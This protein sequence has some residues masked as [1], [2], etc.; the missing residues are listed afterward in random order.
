MLAEKRFMEEALKEARSASFE[1]EAPVGAVVVRDGEVISRGHNE[2]EKYGDAS[3]H[4]EMLALKRAAFKLGTRY[5]T[6]CV[7]YV[8]MEPCPMCAGA[9]LHFRLGAVCFGAYDKNAGALGSVTDIGCGLFGKELPV[10][11]GFMRE[12]CA[13]LL[14]E[15]FKEKR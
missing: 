11:G 6:D 15:Y 2:V 3:R 10:Y 1:G 12:E 4:A 14:N 5:L 8:T 13:S 7:L 9:C